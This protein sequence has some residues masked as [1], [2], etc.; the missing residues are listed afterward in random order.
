MYYVRI[1]S[2]PARTYA[3]CHTHP[4][5]AMQH[6]CLVLHNSSTLRVGG[7]S[8]GLPLP[9]LTE[10]CTEY[11]DGSAHATNVPCQLPYN[12]GPG[13]KYGHTFT[14]MIICFLGQQLHHGSMNFFGE[15]PQC[16]IFDIFRPATVNG[17]T[18]HLEWTQRVFEPCI[19]GSIRFHL[20]SQL[21]DGLYLCLMLR[22]FLLGRPL[23]HPLE[24]L[25]KH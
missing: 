22:H 11:A 14:I 7:F 17:V 3:S 2:G 5:H 8:M 12:W 10:K 4:R 23:G 6:T 15:P 20:F 16:W 9:V 18:T 13:L 24:S 25:N 19:F 1:D 21:F